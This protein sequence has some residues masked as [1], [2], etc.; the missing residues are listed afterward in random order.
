MCKSKNRDFY[1]GAPIK[2]MCD[3][4]KA[5]K[6]LESED[7]FAPAYW[8]ED[9]RG[10]KGQVYVMQYVKANKNPSRNYDSW[11]YQMD[12]K[13]IARMSELNGQGY[14]VYSILIG[15]MEHG[16]QEIVYVGYEDAMDCLGVDKG[17][18]G[19][20]NITV[21]REPGKRSLRVYG[22]GRSIV[23]GGRDNAIHIKRNSA[24]FLR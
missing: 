19:Q 13:K 7:R 22:S 9:E 2:M 10:G 24:P 23:A 16:D 4:G 12:D 20:R 14:S 21:R 3:A 15:L 1:Y 5:P 8:L 18:R 11:T 6:R 17:T